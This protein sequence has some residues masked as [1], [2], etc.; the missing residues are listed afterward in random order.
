VSHWWL[1]EA[2][3]LRNDRAS[4]MK[5][6]AADAPADK[7][8]ASSAAAAATPAAKAETSR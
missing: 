1:A 3:A 2:F 7:N 5:A 4:S 6:T 8:P